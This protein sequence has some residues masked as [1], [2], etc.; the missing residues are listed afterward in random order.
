LPDPAGQRDCSSVGVIKL[1][2]PTKTGLNQEVISRKLLLLFIYDITY[3][4][5]LSMNRRFY[6]Y[7]PIGR[8][9]PVLWGQCKFLADILSQE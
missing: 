1:I 9:Y 3:M 2:I 4:A 6:P 7:V 5:L 8:I